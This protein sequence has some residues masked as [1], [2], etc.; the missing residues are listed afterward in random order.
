[1]TRQI[2]VFVSSGLFVNI[3]T[4]SLWTFLCQTRI[5][6]DAN[7]SYIEKTIVFFIRR[8]FDIFVTGIRTS[9]H[10]I[11][12]S[13]RK[14]VCSSELSPNEDRIMLWF[15]NFFSIIES[16]ERYQM[17]PIFVDKLSGWRTRKLISYAR[18]F[19]VQ[20]APER[21]W[22]RGLDIITVPVGN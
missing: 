3:R 6:F 4:I 21:P 10:I 19:V 12:I 18:W 15:N 16:V 11:L 2:F 20:N 17:M 14:N 9:V 13:D 22:A 7:S 8:E 1:M 5:D